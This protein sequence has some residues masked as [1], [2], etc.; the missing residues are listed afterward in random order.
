VIRNTIFFVVFLL[1]GSLM[2][3]NGPFLRF[4]VGPGIMNEFNSIKGSGFTMVAKNHAIGWGFEN[5]YAVSYSEFGAFVRK[6]I[7]EGVRY[8]NLDAYGLGF[9][10]HTQNH[11]SFQLSGAYGTVHFSDRW[12]KQ[13]DY[14]EDGFAA[15]LGAGRNWLL[16]R[17]IDLGAGPQ[18]F[19]LKTE[20]Y[21]FTDISFNLWLDLYLFPQR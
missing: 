9:A 8:I 3:Q 17:R 4:S 2:A 5:K 14:I 12:N 21:S 20:T 19:I 1:S 11:F 15:A 16:S 18:A 13:G 6:S 7:G 10:C